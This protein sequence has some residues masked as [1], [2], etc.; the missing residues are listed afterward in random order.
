[1][2]NTVKTTAVSRWRPAGFTLVELLVVVGIIALL[3]SIL[4]P[5]LARARDQAR[6]V[7]CLAHMRRAAQAA[8]AL[9]NQQNGRFQI[10]TDEVG[11]RKA[12]PNRSIYRYDKNR[13]LLAWPTALAAAS[14]LG[15]DANED[16]GI[17]AKSFRDAY[18][19]QKEIERSGGFDLLM[20]PS[21]K[22][23]VSTPFYPRNKGSNN[24]GLKIDINGSDDGSAEAK[25]VVVTDRGGHRLGLRVH[26]VTGRTTIVE[27]EELF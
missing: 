8:S 4:L 11:L 10:A 3:I 21:D 6:L 14:G 1:M 27:A 5:S 12:D 9:A 18:E 7:K 2:R 25:D 22:V 15:Y 26:P 17:R 13:E 16:W 20:C 24:N 19:R 23:R